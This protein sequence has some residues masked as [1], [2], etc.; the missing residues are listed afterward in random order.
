[1]I[2]VV[3]TS[4]QTSSGRIIE[5][6]Q[7]SVTLHKSQVRV[8]GSFPLPGVFFKYS[9]AG[10]K[11]EKIDQS[12]SFTSFITRTFSILG[13]FYIVFGFFYKLTSKTIDI[14]K[15]KD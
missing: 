7:Y 4:Y 13:G 6:H 2:N 14:V 5:S 11:M 9:F 8:G 12:S 10:L 1:M 15:K 3:P